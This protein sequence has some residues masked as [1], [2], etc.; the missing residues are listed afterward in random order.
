MSKADEAL[1]DV[2]RLLCDS[3][4][5]GDAGKVCGMLSVVSRCIN[6]LEAENS[7]LRGERDH[8][9][10]EQVHAYGNWEDAN[11]WASELQAENAKLRELITDVHEALCADKVG[12]FHKLILE[13]MED[14]MRNL[15]IEVDE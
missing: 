1:A 15:G 9:H 6:E 14:D 13:S 3:L 10:V 4:S 12:M 7:K 8:W 11:K 5:D 2:R